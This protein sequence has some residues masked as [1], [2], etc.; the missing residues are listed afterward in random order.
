MAGV[1]VWEKRLLFGSTAATLLAFLF[2]IV[3]V[4]TTSWIH[5]E[6]RTTLVQNTSG[7]DQFLT[8]YS[9]GLWRSCEEGYTLDGQGQ[10]VDFEECKSH[11]FFPEDQELKKDKK[12]DIQ[13]VDYVRTGSAFAI[14]SLL[15]MML[16]HIFAF[17]RSGDHGISS[18]D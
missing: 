17:T 4:G 6:F 14:I 5:I 15:I 13:V 8:G 10:K 11:K 18:S 3:A 7:T 9:G 12:T 1:L 2:Q 16:G